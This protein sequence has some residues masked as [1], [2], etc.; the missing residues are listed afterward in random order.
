MIKSTPSSVDPI[1][2]EL[3]TNRFRTLVLEMGHLLQRVAISTNIKERLDFSCALLN[4]RGDLVVN[5]PHI[6]VHLGALPICVKAIAGL[7]DLKDGDTAITNHPAHG[8][9]H[10]P[11]ITLITPVFVNGKR[12]AYFATRAHHAELG[13]KNPGSLVPGAKYLDEEG[14]VIHP[15]KLV[16]NSVPQWDEIR[17]ILLSAKYPTRAV[18]ENIADLR[19]QLAANQLGKKQLEQLSDEQGPDDILHVMESILDDSDVRLRVLW[20]TME[21]AQFSATEQLDNGSPIDLSINIQKGVATVDFT[22]TGPVNTG[23]LNSPPA[24]IHS[25]LLYVLRLLARNEQ[26]PLALN[27]GLMRSIKLIIPEGTFINPATNEADY[28]AV[29]GG[30][31]EIS[32]RVV[33]TL[34]K[35]FGL[36]AC[37]QG[38]MNNIV[39]GNEKFGVYETICGG[40]GATS[41]AA[42]ASG[43]HTHMTNTRITD[44]E[45]LER[46]YPV[47][48]IRF[49]LR[50]N[51]GGKGFH[52]GGE[53]IIREYEFLDS[54]QVSLLA[55][56]RVVEPYGMDGG[57]NGSVGEQFLINKTGEHKLTGQ[58]SFVVKPGDRVRILTP[59]GGGFGTRSVEE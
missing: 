29:M 28:P 52:K 49:E 21:S 32:Q 24:I 23:N 48:L 46:R 58:E 14:V 11:D 22:G 39:F 7:L 17:T 45:I 2:R 15:T 40:A 16:V 25:A 9:S 59:G 36:A 18:E 47:R 27:S 6:P 12:I 51:S 43:V 53:G 20:R 3:L 38:T 56:H 37:S 44:P 10:L 55:E 50:K 42:G 1:S 19:A 4:H 30:N 35:A 54:L 31:V 57:E 34:I 41:K 33:D 5:A 13:G 8:G 26:P